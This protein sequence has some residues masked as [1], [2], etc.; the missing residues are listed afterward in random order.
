MI[1]D[2]AVIGAG[3]MGVSAARFL[4]AYSGKFCV[5]EKNEDVCTGTSKA[6]SAIVHAGFDAEPGS[7]KAKYNLL[8]SLMYPQLAEE[9]DIPFRR[10]GSLVVMMHEEDRPKLMELYERGIA[11]GVEDLEII[12]RERLRGLEPHIS[13]NAVAALWAPTGGIVCPFLATVALAENAADNGVDFLFGTEVNALCRVKS[14]VIPERKDLATEHGYLWEIDTSK[15]AVYARSVINA[16]GVMSD[17]YHNLVSARKIRIIP[18]KG[19][20]VLLDRITGGYVERTIFQLPGKLGKGVLVSPT[21]HGNTLVGPTAEEQYDREAVNTTFDGISDLMEK[22]GDT[23]SGIPFREVITSFAGVRAHEVGG[24]FIIGEP[25]DAPLFYDCAG[26][27]SPGLTAAPAIGKQA[28]TDIAEKLG[29]K[30]N[31]SFNGT[32]KGFINPLEMAPEELAELIRKNP[33]YGK[34]VCRCE[35]VTEGEIRDAIRR[36][37]GAKSLDGVKR[38]VRA[39]MGRC[40]SGFCSPRVMD[41][42]SEELGIP[43]SE[44]TKKGGYSRIIADK[45]KC[46][47]GEDK[48]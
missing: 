11:N 31:P 44:I 7:L 29:L 47:S 25:E 35:G 17:I 5:I 28:A 4:S 12:G 3:I 10:N 1:Y 34:I 41:I 45:I 26:I 48:R 9:L 19:E 24:D 20:Y 18:R 22:A 16:A 8:G 15:G 30:T 23:V 2:A 6:N 39:G 27:E 21:I 33:D 32:R 42:L 37:V 46:C 14:A 13:E 43:V 36:K 38:R 40:Q